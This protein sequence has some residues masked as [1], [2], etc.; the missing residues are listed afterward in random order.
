MRRVL[1][2]L[3]ALT[4]FAAMQPGTAQAAGV[5]PSTCSAAAP[6]ISW[7]PYPGSTT[8]KNTEARSTGIT[9]A[10]TVWKVTKQQIQIQRSADPGLMYWSTLSGSTLI[11]PTTD[12]SGPDWID[13]ECAHSAKTG[14]A[15]CVPSYPRRALSIYTILN[16]TTGKFR[17]VKIGSPIQYS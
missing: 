10:G 14:V 16:T 12:P 17:I 13:F 6:T 1:V 2:L 5:M 3:A 15:V 7:V 4:A 8:L 11:P 9:C